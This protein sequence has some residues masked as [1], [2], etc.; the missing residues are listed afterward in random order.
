MTVFASFYAQTQYS[1]ADV[2]QRD[3]DWVNPGVLSSTDLQVTAQSPAA[4]AVNV[5]GAA[6]NVAGGSAWLSGGYRLYNDSVLALAIAAADPSN[7]RIDIVVAGINT[8]TTPYTPEIKVITG[9][10]AATPSAPATPSGYLLLAQV[11]VDAGATTIAQANIVDERQIATL[12]VTASQI[13]AIPLSE[14][15][16]P[17]GPATLDEQG[18]VFATQ[19]GNAHGIPYAVDSSAT[20]NTV[21]VTLNPAP[22]SY[23]DGFAVC[24][25][26]ANASTGAST[27]NINNLGPIPLKNGD[28]T[29]VG[30]GDLVAGVPVT[31]RYVGGA[32]PAFIASGS[33]GLS[34]T[35]NATAADVL[36]PYTFTSAS[37]KSQSG[38][39]VNQGAVTLTASGNGPVPIPQGYHNG[40]GEVAQVAI[41]AAHLLTG[42]TVAG[43]AGTMPNNGAVTLTPS[44]NGPVAIPAGYHNGSGVVAQVN[45]PAADVLTGTNIAGVAGTMPNNGS[46][47]FTP[48]G[49]AQGIP[50]GY[51]SGGTIEASPHQ[52]ASGTAAVSGGSVLPF[53]FSNGS[54]DSTYYITVGGLTFTPSLVFVQYPG[55]TT[56][57]ICMPS[58]SFE[59]NGQI[60]SQYGSNFDVFELTGN[61]YINGSGFQLPMPG[62]AASTVNWYAYK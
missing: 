48:S 5:N 37:G 16:E 14:L 46:P 11:N 31:F 43:V 17:G 60:F 32:S 9:T 23:T 38:E 18:Q 35:G 1:P 59:T 49:S 10:P 50:A 55:S 8:T 36:T 58:S 41:T 3:A 61:A 62:S 29:A 39:M 6:Q 53:T 33:G 40:S 54:T 45:V 47:T 7:P 27:L 56:F 52:A 28:G 34:G 2:M 20:A 4:M 30:V 21:V 51:Y 26:I 12:K 57:T 25:K 13:G 24:V 15:G 22:T 19:L 44:G 42:D